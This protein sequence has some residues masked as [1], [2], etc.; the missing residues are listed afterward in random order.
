MS[1]SPAEEY[2]T[3]ERRWWATSVAPVAK[4]GVSRS[5]IFSPG[6]TESSSRPNSLA[7][8]GRRLPGRQGRGESATDRAPDSK[9]NS[10]TG[11]ESCGPAT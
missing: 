1:R 7:R 11:R 6:T 9:D 3:D 5:L 4:W 10:R 2:L 8:I